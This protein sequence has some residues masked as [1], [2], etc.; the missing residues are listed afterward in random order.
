M[1]ILTTDGWNEYELLDSGDGYR[2]ERFGQYKVVKPDPQAIW[3][4]S[5]PKD[6]WDGADAIF[7]KDV[8]IK[9]D[10]PDKW[11]VKYHDLSFY[12]RLTPFKHTGIFPEQHLH[13]DYIKDA[14]T[15]NNASSQILNLFAYTGVAS[16]A[17][18]AAGASVTHVDASRPA[19]TWAHE[20]QELSNLSEKPIRW[21]LDDVTRF[22]EKE[23]R[24]GKKY[25]GIIMD[26]PIYGHGPNGEVWDFPKSFP[27]LIELCSQLLSDKPL[28][29]IVN[30]YAISASSIM[31]ENV[32]RDYLKEGTI[33]IGELALKEKSAGRLLST[34]IFAKWSIT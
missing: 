32:L 13:W 17:A 31:L 5:L 7:E 30:A 28:F 27:K 25:E 16:L 11:L 21:I 34:G 12:A 18:A 8:W 15:K 26:P 20:N 3:K 10:V 19:I 33:E 14:V 2:L 6:E 22:V 23:V 29:I 24:R 1:H 4:R 9:K